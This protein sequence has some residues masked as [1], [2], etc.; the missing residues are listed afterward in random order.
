MDSAGLLAT[1]KI[2]P[3]IGD[4]AREQL[5]ETGSDTWLLFAMMLGLLIAAMISMRQIRIRN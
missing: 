1:A 2:T 3:T 4:R 5:P